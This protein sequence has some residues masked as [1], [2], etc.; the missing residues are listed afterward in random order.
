MPSSRKGDRQLTFIVVARTDPGPWPHPVEVALHPAGPDS[1]MS[2]SVGPHAANSG[3]Q[4]A[5]SRVLDDRRTGLNPMF[6]EEFASGDLHWLVPYL[7]RLHN[8]E[9]VEDEIVEA[10]AARHG[11]APQLMGQEF[12]GS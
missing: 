9:D 11:R 10:Y 12:F 6:D 5:L 1:R 2:F 3:G 8:G 4:L 7:V